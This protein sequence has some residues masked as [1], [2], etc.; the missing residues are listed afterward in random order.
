M[1][2]KSSSS[3]EPLQFVAAHSIRVHAA[4]LF[5]KDL[6]HTTDDTSGDACSRKHRPTSQTAPSPLM[7]AWRE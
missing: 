1:E 4:A 3:E 5:K 7:I 6:G 2:L